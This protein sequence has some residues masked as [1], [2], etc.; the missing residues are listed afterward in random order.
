MIV[1]DGRGV[2][3]DVIWLQEAGLIAVCSRGRGRASRGGVWR[4][5]CGDSC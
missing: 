4:R 1:E 3:W 2:G 5:A